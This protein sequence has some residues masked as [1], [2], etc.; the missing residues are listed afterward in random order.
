MP[1]I[2]LVQPVEPL[3][4]TPDGVLQPVRQRLRRSSPTNAPEQ[5]PQRGELAV[6][7]TAVRRTGP[8]F[9]P[10]LPGRSSIS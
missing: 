4:Q 9:L 1:T 6:Q 8:S 3:A 2:S 10:S 7:R 5:Q